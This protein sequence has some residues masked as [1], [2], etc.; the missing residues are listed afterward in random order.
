M[1]I[2]NKPITRCNGDEKLRPKVK[3]LFDKG[4]LWIACLLVYGFFK[5][6]YMIIMSKIWY[7]RA[8][9]RA[10][11]LMDKVVEDAR[12]RSK[13]SKWQVMTRNFFNKQNLLSLATDPDQVAIFGRLSVGDLAPPGVLYTLDK[14]VYNFHQIFQQSPMNI[15]VLN[16]AEFITIYIAEAHTTDDWYIPDL[17]DG[18]GLCFHAPDTLDDK[19]RLANNFRNDFCYKL[20]FYVDSMQNDSM[21]AYS[22]KPERIYIV[23][24]GRIAFKGGPG[25]FSYALDEIDDALRKL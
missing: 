16:F 8:F 21:R 12:Q 9:C 19:I 10:A 1:R 13:L 24:D 2:K 5:M 14:E 18:A 11:K 25:P 15:F 23:K 7:P 22:A 20:P 6:M 17:N 4:R 3:T